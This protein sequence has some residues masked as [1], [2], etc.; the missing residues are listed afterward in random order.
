MI[1]FVN[2]R[3]FGRWFFT[4]W[5]CI[6]TSWLYLAKEPQEAFGALGLMLLGWHA[7]IREWVQ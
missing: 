5:A 7:A 3:A 6:W 2:S 4:T 1:E